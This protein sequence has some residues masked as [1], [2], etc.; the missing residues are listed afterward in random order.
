MMPASRTYDFYIKKFKIIHNNFYIYPKHQELVNRTKTYIDIKCPKHGWFKQTIESHFRGRGCKKCSHETVG[1]LNA[2]S[3]NYY[4]GKAKNKH[5]DFY[6]YPK[7]QDIKNNED[8]IMIKCPKHGWFKQKLNNHLN[9]NG[10]PK[11]GYEKTLSYL[12]KTFKEHIKECRLVHR[13]KYEYKEPSGHYDIFTKIMIKC[14]KHGWFKQTIDSHKRGNGCPDCGLEKR[15][16]KTK[17]TYDAYIK[18]MKLIHDNFYKYPKHQDLI[19]GVYTK[20]KIRCPKHGWFKQS[21]NNHK[22]GHGCPKCTIGTS[23]AE[24]EIS[25]WLKSIGI[26]NIKNNYKFNYEGRRFEIDVYLPDFN[27]GIEH[28]GLYWHSD[29]LKSKGYHK[30]KT[31]FFKKNFNIDIIHIF[32]NEWILKSKIVKSII[33]SKLNKSENI[34]YARKCI[35]KEIDNKLYKSFLMNNHIQGYIQAKYKY[36]LFFNDD[37]VQVMSFGKSRYN[38]D[39]DFENIRSCTKINTQIIGGLSK[40][41]KYFIKNEN[42]K[43][44]ISYVDLR[45]FNGNG[46]IKNN[47]KIIGQSEPNY[48]YFHKTSMILESRLRY[49]KHKLEKILDNFDVG[50]S[51]YENMINNDYLRIF[52]C[53]NLKLLYTS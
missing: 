32:Q 31:E 9:G 19:D 34:L 28:D 38:K 47:F 7:H 36:G 43:S 4:I 14:P 22:K 23:K 27:L 3:Y 16:E 13:N 20:I 11:C 18:I 37:L 41:L 10:C 48:F 29:Q 24:E 35:I 50:L 52:D 46:Y 30:E 5:D 15:V 26:K 8:K 1:R 6:H 44:I 2:K 21:L 40:L 51:E 49:Q 39:Y 17:I 33:L 12:K 42:P 53:G 25:S 45:Y